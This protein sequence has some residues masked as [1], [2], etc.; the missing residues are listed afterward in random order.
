M[1]KP[2]KQEKHKPAIRV[3]GGGG[4]V[5]GGV[6]LWGGVVA[7]A[8][9]LSVSAIRLRKRPTNKSH[10]PPPPPKLTSSS[11][12]EAEPIADLPDKLELKKKKENN[13]DD[14]G[15]GL[16]V[17]LQD[18]S[19]PI[20][21]HPSTD[22][23]T[24]TPVTQ[25]DSTSSDFTK[26]SILDDNSVRDISGP[27]KSPTY[28]EILLS[29][30]SKPK[31]SLLITDYGV[32]VNVKEYSLPVLDGPSLLKSRNMNK[33]EH[34]GDTVDV[35]EDNLPMELIEKGGGGEVE[36]HDDVENTIE[37][38]EV[39]VMEGDSI[40]SEVIWEDKAVE[41]PHVGQ[42]EEVDNRHT[43]LIETVIEKG[44]E[45]IETA[46]KDQFEVEV[47]Q[48]A[49][50]VTKEE[51]A[52]EATD[53]VHIEEECNPKMQLIEE[54]QEN[55]D[56]GIAV[57]KD[58]AIETV[59]PTNQVAVDQDELQ[60]TVLSEDEDEDEDED[61][62]EMDVDEDEDEEEIVEKG[63]ESSDGTG[64]SS[65]ESNAEA[66]WPA[67]S[68]QELSLE[69]KELK[70]FSKTLADKIDE[71]EDHGCYS[72]SIA[73]E[74]NIYVNGHHK[75]EETGKSIVTAS[76]G[77]IKELLARIKLSTG[78]SNTRIWI[79]VL[80]VLLLLV[81]PLLLSPANILKLCLIIF[82][83]VILSQV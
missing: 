65:M 51:A 20:D 43:Q 60:V 75:N 61:D 70:I 28:L 30:N 54:E 40:V 8:T 1:E 9:F 10:N 47:D 5:V 26:T 79:S 82:L 19:P 58:E 67:E 72:N 48:E 64:D 27:T 13:D 68:I 52:N 77:S 2:K 41:A 32:N 36:E 83:V 37:I 55:D 11:Q 81:M 18:Y 29:D 45:T 80:L 23:T 22:G 31:N 69:F 49:I 50:K 73:D 59:V 25:I 71:A 62:D 21:Y 14:Q 53:A 39:V 74:G 4:G 76:K 66:I 15:K 7:A 12:S 24:E 57:E 42:I 33:N 44:E 3:G 6:V 34:I 46:E 63:E 35:E 38:G 78:A 16:H 56:G 17:L